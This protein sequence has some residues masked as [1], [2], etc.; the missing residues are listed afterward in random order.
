M[1]KDIL[2]GLLSERSGGVLLAVRLVPNASKSAI[3][4]VIRDAEGHA[5]LKVRVTAIAEKGKA[6]A[7][8]IKLLAKRTGIAKTRFTI[9]SGASD[10]RKKLLIEGETETLMGQLTKWLEELS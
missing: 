3:D 4:G 7:A 9:S 5:V 6:N 1:A 10:R 8:L 2:S